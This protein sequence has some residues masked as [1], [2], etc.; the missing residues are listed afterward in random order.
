[1]PTLNDLIDQFGSNAFVLADRGSGSG[2]GQAGITTEYDDA[3]AAKYGAV[4]MIELPAPHTA[5]DG[6][7]CHY[8][9]EWID[10]TPINDAGYLG[11]PYAVCLFF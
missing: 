9:G 4:E 5:S 2:Y 6:T 1:M 11:Q 3:A 7:E 8:A 10:L